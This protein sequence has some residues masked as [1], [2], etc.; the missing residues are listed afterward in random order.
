MK[1]AL[2]TATATVSLAGQV[3]AADLPARVERPLPA[4]PII[5]AGYYDWTGFY[6]GGHGGGGWSN[7][8]Y[9]VQPADLSDGCHDGSGWLAGGQIGYNLQSGKFVLG[10]EFAGSWADISGSHRSVLTPTDTYNSD[11]NAIVLLTGRLGLT[12]DRVLLYVGG[13]GAW[14][15]DKFAYTTGGVGTDTLNRNRTGWTIGGGFEYG[16]TPYWSVAG[17]YNYVSLGN[18]GVAFDGPTVFTA[19]DGQ[20]MLLASLRLN[21]RF[22]IGRPAAPPY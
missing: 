4:A 20:E 13:G 9:T 19:N 12:F 11:V 2:L 10:F 21:Y 5:V 16:L 14:V 15:R 1:K 6:I 18:K 3:C 8:C 17:Q 22:G 7:K